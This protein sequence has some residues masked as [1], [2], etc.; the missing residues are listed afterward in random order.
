MSRIWQFDGKVNAVVES[1][2]CVPEIPFPDNQAS[3]RAL[4]GLPFLVKGADPPGLIY[5]ANMLIFC[6]FSGYR[7]V[8][9]RVHSN[10]MYSS[11]LHELELFLCMIP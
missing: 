8:L 4:E 9:V 10:P 2:A 1:S 3:P 11:A 5:L 6:F 7:M